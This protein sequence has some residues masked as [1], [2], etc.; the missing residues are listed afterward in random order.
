MTAKQTETLKAIASKYN[1]SIV[2]DQGARV[3]LNVHRV[4]RNT[5]LALVKKGMLARESVGNPLFSTSTRYT[6][7]PAGHAALA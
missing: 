6:V 2:T 5:L 7:T 3:P 1:S 4:S